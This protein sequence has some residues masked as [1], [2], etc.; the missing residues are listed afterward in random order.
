MKKK[1]ILVCSVLLIVCLGLFL[2]LRKSEFSVVKEVELGEDFSLVD[3]ADDSFSGEFTIVEKDSIFDSKGMIPM[4]EYKFVVEDAHSRGRFT[5]VVRD[6]TKPSFTKFSDVIQI[7]DDVESIDWSEY[8]VGKDFS[9]VSLNVDGNVDF[10]C[11]GEFPIDVILEDG[12]KNKVKKS[13]LV[14]IDKEK[15]V[16]TAGE[17]SD[18]NTNSNTNGNDN[19]V[20]APS[21]FS[22]VSPTYVQGILVV[23]KLHPIPADFAYGEDPTAGVQI[24]KLIADM[25]S[26]GYSISTSYSGYRSNAYQ[27][28]LYNGYVASSGQAAADTYSARPGFSEHETGLAFDLIDGSGQLVESEAEAE[29]IRN[30]AHEYG[31]IVR[32]PFGKES[33]TGFMPEPW[34]LR[35][36]GAR[37]GEIYSSGLCLEEFLGVEGGSQYR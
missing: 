34:H 31:F 11:V 16:E 1:L 26:L 29:W 18:V 20:L 36:I 9:G 13:A 21:T 24:R 4:G 5:V 32:Y 25:Q 30:H 19:N 23:N 27:R 6:T 14:V 22:D 3:L 12:E 2:F 17:N 35:Y 37:A 10:G 15:V 28:N 33:I 8:F 7:T